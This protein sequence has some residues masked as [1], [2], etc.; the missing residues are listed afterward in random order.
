[1]K[2]PKI[3]TISNIKYPKILERE[4]GQT[5]VNGDNTYNGEELDH[6]E[7]TELI[8]QDEVINATTIKVNNTW[9]GE[10]MKE[11]QFLG[12]TDYE[13]LI[14]KN[15]YYVLSTRAL[16][17]NSS[18]TGCNFDLI[19]IA[20]GKIQSNWLYSNWNSNNI[21]AK[22][23]PIITLNSSVQLDKV[24]SGDGSS[25]EKAYAIK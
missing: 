10:E 4:K 25:P 20:W 14:E 9:F 11:E 3:F 21:K 15:G 2:N 24:N 17:P 1:M 19:W 18:E 7:Q 5:V 8:E 12:K 22:F 6:S 16:N 13:M 23:R